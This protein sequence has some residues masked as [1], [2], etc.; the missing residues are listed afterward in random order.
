MSEDATAFPYAAGIAPVMWVF[1]AMSA[2]EIPIL[3]L[4]LPAG[5]WRIGALILGAWGLLW[6]VG[7]LASMHVHPHLMEPD[8]LR[9][10]Y[11]TSIDVVVPWHA[12]ESVNRHSRNLAKSRTVQVD[13]TG[14]GDA[15]LLVVN[16]QTN[17]DIRF[18]GPLSLGIR[19]CP[20]PVTAI[21]CYADDPA[22]FVALANDHLTG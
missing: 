18:R 10:R 22:V 5:W 12:I 7:L 8:G 1:I 14:H 16:S 11:G 21:R 2:V 3:H 19:R 17:V 4:L 13:H 20:D 15:C 6:M 9:L